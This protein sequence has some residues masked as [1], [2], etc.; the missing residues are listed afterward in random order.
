MKKYIFILL[1]FFVKLSFGQ[2]PGCPNVDAGPDQTT[3]CANPCVDLTATLLQTGQTDTYTVTSIPYAPPFPFSGGTGVSVN[4]DDVYSG[5]ITLPFDF[6]FFGQAYNQVVVGSNGVISFDVSQAGAYCPWSFSASVPSSS[7]PTNAIFGSYL[8]IDPSVCGNVYYDITGSYPCRT[9]VFKFDQ[10]CYFSCTYLVTSQE[11]V[12][13]EGTNAI[14]VYI[15]NHPVCSGWNSGNAVIGIQNS[16]GSVGFTPPGRNTG[17]WTTSNEAWRFTPSGT[18]NFTVNWYEN[19]NLIGTG[20]TINVCPTAPAGSSTTYTAEAIYNNCNGS[21]IV[22]TDDVNV[23]NTSTMS[24]S[25]SFTDPTCFGSSDG[26]AS[27]S[28]TSNSPP[29]T[30]SWGTGSNSPTIINLSSGTYDVTITDNGGCSITSSVTLTDPPQI[31]VDSTITKPDTCGGNSGSLQIYASGGTGTLHYDLGT[32]SNTTGNFTNISSGNYTIT[33]T[34]DNNCSITQTENVG[35]TGQVTAGFTSSPN[36]CLT[37]N[38]FDFTNTGDTGPGL[39]WQWTF[40][41]ANTPT[42]TL[43][44]PTGISWSSPGTYTVTQTLSRGT[45]QDISTFDITVWPM[46]I[47]SASATDVTCYEGSDGTVTANQSSGTAPFTYQWNDPNSSTSQTTTGLAVGQY[48]VTIT[49]ANGCTDSATTTINQPL[50]PLQVTVTDS[51]DVL[52]FGQSNGSIDLNVSGG[53]FPYSYN[54]SNSVTTQDN[55]NIPAGNYTV[56]V[57][58]VNNCTSIRTITINQPSQITYTNTSTDVS[59]HGYSDGTASIQPSGG[60]PPYY[61]HWNNNSTNQSNTNLYPGDYSVTVTDANGCHFDTTINVG[62]PDEVIAAVSPRDT[63]CIGQTTTVYT[64]GTGGTPPYTYIW[65]NGQTS[66]SFPVNPDTTTIYSVQATDSHG[67][68]SGLFYTTV[69]VY[70]PLSLDFDVSDFS[71]CK[72]DPVLLTMYPSGG[73]GHYI[74]SLNNGNIINNPSNYYTSGNIKETIKVI[75]ND[76]CGTPSAFDTM[77]INIL[78]LPEF[79][80]QPNITNGCQPLEVKFNA[81]SSDPNLS[82]L[83]NFGDS[84]ENSNLSNKPNPTHT[85]NESGV[86]N[87]QLVA[88]NDSGCT[89][90]LTVNNLIKVYKN[91]EA[92]FVTDPEIIN[93]I[94]PIINFNNYSI[95]ANSYT[96]FFG[97]NDS[98]N[99]ENPTH[100]YNIN[101]DKYT[102]MLIAETSLGCKDTV[103]QDIFVKESLT[104]YAPTAFTPDDDGINDEWK[105]GA[106]GIDNSNFELFIFDRWGE[107]IFSTKDYKKGWDGKAKNKKIAENGTYTWV[108]RFKDVNGD[109]YERLGSFVLYR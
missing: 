94:K 13:Y 30:Y 74:Y 101:S 7:L 52:C 12:L 84:N 50:N 49:D 26:T 91:P 1:I 66:S 44:N 103:T 88:K 10:V 8:D 42:S 89:N 69:F 3:T 55:N 14:E 37:G 28:G 22:V 60:T 87:V 45:C 33:I 96:W 6:C 90:S 97:D 5:V 27:A 107:I 36:Q 79:T 17:S 102:V 24:V 85:Y 70:P 73:N 57:T 99:V 61:Y 58:D 98:S 51:S 67:C 48:S 100:T 23:L 39:S 40:Q 43:E 34:D 83:W 19:G 93:N 72:G 11:V 104:F 64:S 75:L 71:V 9:F 81:I 86:F 4:T 54:W 78:P 80:F 29:V 47:A 38:S 92:K 77:T 32:G 2:A 82:Y 63:I 25:T 20:T 35:L 31:V 68:V 16:S 59:C 56:T 46:P 109:S 62:E 95:D 106:T 41:G 65:S 21:N 108:A 105:I 76:N 15:Q 18:P 53:T